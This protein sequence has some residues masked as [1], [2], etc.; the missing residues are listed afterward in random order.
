MSTY[1][2]LEVPEAHYPEMLEY[3][4]SRITGAPTESLMQEAPEVTLAH[5]SRVWSQ[6]TWENVWPDLADGTRE[7]LVLLAEHKGDWVSVAAVENAAG[8]F[9]A[10]QGALI[11]FTKRMKRHG[12][13]KWPFE[14][15]PDDET[16]RLKY[17]MT[18]AMATIVLR[19]AQNTE[20]E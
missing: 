10:M 12:P 15:A 6:E 20:V 17:R 9:G 11:S 8:S 16:G 13:T 2:S 1:V 3:L 5:D 19:L 18:A 7:I 14:I 4:V